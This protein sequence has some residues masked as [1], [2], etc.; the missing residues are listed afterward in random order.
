MGAPRDRGAGGLPPAA[1]AAPLSPAPAAG[2]SHV[3]QRVLSAVQF[4]WVLG[5][6][7]VDGLTDWLR[8]FTRHHRAMSDVLRAERY[9]YTQALL[10]VSARAHTPEPRAGP[11]PGNCHPEPLAAPQG[12]EVHRGLLDQLYARGAEAAPPGSSGARDAPG[13]AARWVWAGGAQEAAGTRRTRAEPPRCGRTDQ[14][15]C[16]L[17]APEP[18]QSRGR[19]ACL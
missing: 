11:S 8:T 17:P 7:L 10:R 6:A 16:G 12:Q 14:E 18:G 2:H 4:L 19:A 13:A 3:M 1:S 5:Q 9:L 15:A